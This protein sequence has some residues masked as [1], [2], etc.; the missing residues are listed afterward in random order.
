MNDE[1]CTY[2]FMVKGYPC[3]AE[4]KGVFALL[5][6][7]M[8]EIKK[9]AAGNLNSLTVNGRNLLVLS[10]DKDYINI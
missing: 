8:G 3:E 5:L 1:F 10:G 2:R 9:I 4:F 6:D 7:D